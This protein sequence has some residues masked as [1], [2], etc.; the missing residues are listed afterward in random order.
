MH[1]LVVWN[2]QENFRQ[3]EAMRNLVRLELPDTILRRHITDAF[4]AVLSGIC[5][6]NKPEISS[7]KLSLSTGVIYENVWWLESFFHLGSC[8]YEAGLRTS[9]G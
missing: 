6:E 3:C 7:P 1:N 8:F 2:C 9:G 4:E 5:L